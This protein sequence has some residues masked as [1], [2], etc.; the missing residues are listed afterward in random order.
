M[1]SVFR[2]MSYVILRSSAPSYG[3]IA[4]PAPAAPVSLPSASPVLTST[5]AATSAASTT[6][7]EN[8]VRQERL[9]LLSRQRRGRPG[10]ILTSPRGLFMPGLRTGKMLLGE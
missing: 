8:A 3:P 6:A 2:I 4:L 9:D 1:A 10:L 7:E 5:T